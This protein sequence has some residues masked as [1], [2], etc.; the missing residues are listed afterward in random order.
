M[1]TNW[2]IP[3]D[4]ERQR[5]VKE[6]PV[7]ICLPIVKLVISCFVS[8]EDSICSAAGRV[9]R[10]RNAARVTWVTTNLSVALIE[11]D[12]DFFVLSYSRRKVIVI[13]LILRAP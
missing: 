1:A 5:I 11:V 4:I 6:I 8:G 9:G 3:G 2:F 13:E 10:A 12:R 7:N